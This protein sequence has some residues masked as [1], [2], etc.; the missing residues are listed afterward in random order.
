MTY[1]PLLD[2]E[3]RRRRTIS[4]LL[5]GTAHHQV[6]VR[7]AETGTDDG[8]EWERSE[9]WPAGTTEAARVMQLKILSEITRRRT[10]A[11]PRE[12]RERAAPRIVFDLHDDGTATIGYP[13]EGDEYVGP[14]G[15]TIE[16]QGDMGVEVSEADRVAADARVEQELRDYRWRGPGDPEDGPATRQYSETQIRDMLREAPPTGGRI[17]THIRVDE[18]EDELSSSQRGGANQFHYR[19][20]DR[21]RVE[22]RL[23]DARQ[24]YREAVEG[25]EPSA[26]ERAMQ[27]SIDRAPDHGVDEFFGEEFD[28]EGERLAQ[29]Y[30]VHAVSLAE[31]L[32]RHRGDIPVGNRVELV[33]R[34]SV[35]QADE[36]LQD[37][38]GDFGSIG[39][40]MDYEDLTTGP[41]RPGLGDRES[42]RTS[43]PER[44][45]QAARDLRHHQSMLDSNRSMLSMAED[46]VGDDPDEDRIAELRDAVAEHEAGV[47]TAT[48][49]IANET[50]AASARDLAGRLSQADPDSVTFIDWSAELERIVDENIAQDYEITRG[51]DPSIQ[52]DG[53]SGNPLPNPAHHRA[54]LVRELA[55]GFW[56]VGDPEALARFERRL[57]ALRNSIE[58]ARRSRDPE[59]G[60]ADDVRHRF[61]ARIDNRLAQ[62]HNSRGGADLPADPR[63]GSVPV[64]EPLLGDWPGGGPVLVGDMD[65]AD[66]RTHLDRLSDDDLEALSLEMTFAGAGGVQQLADGTF[67]PLP[68]SPLEATLREQ[69]RRRI[70]G[71]AVVDQMTDDDTMRLIQLV[72][73]AR[74]ERQAVSRPDDRPTR[75]ERDAARDAERR[76]SMVR[77]IDAGRYLE[78]AEAAGDEEQIRHAREIL[79]ALEAADELRSR[80]DSI[81][82]ELTPEEERDSRAVRESLDTHAIEQVTGPDG[83]LI[84]RDGTPG[85]MFPSTARS[86]EGMFETMSVGSLDHRAG[87]VER[88]EV[89]ADLGGPNY[90]VQRLPS[91]SLHRTGVHVAVFTT[92]TVREGAPEAFGTADRGHSPSYHFPAYSRV[93]TLEEVLDML[94]TTGGARRL[95][96]QISEQAWAAILGEGEDR[97]TVGFRLREGVSRD[98]D[99]QHPALR[100]RIAGQSFVGAGLDVEAVR[101]EADRPAGRS[102][103]A[104]ARRV[105]DRGGLAARALAELRLAE[106]EYDAMRLGDRPFLGELPIPDRGPDP[107]LSDRHYLDRLEGREPAEPLDPEVNR[108]ILNTPHPGLYDDRNTYADSN[109][110]YPPVARTD[111]ELIDRAMEDREFRETPQDDASIAL[112]AEVD[113]AIEAAEAD[114]RAEEERVAERRERQR[115][116]LE[117]RPSAEEEGYQPRGGPSGPPAGGDPRRGDRRPSGGRRGDGYS[118]ER[119]NPDDPETGIPAKSSFFRIIYDPLGEEVRKADDPATR[120]ALQKLKASFEKDSKR[121]FRYGPRHPRQVDAGVLKIDDDD[122][123]DII[124]AL[125]EVLGKWARGADGDEITRKQ[126]LLDY[127]Q[128]IENSGGAR[129]PGDTSTETMLPIRIAAVT[130][131]IDMLSQRA[132]DIL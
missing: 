12:R 123:F 76:E 56:P 78:S 86:G 128:A 68:A 98:P 27:A 67:Q 38:D 108:E 109:F 96:E 116:E 7:I 62:I 117:P 77:L 49:A 14:R 18:D 82:G 122:L 16:P 92:G 97:D 41:D 124:D 31:D 120:N 94:T 125:A 3:E 91:G 99:R 46:P 19:P 72:L 9:P 95:R 45:S 131:L 101:T 55:Q 13:A 29:L 26:N 36:T 102:G 110:E 100:A 113:A 79:R 114:Q 80:A 57:Q 4:D 106:Q 87:E 28:P 30:N 83:R 60:I 8:R 21:E 115:R 84:S 71:S 34:F 47:A 2:P 65:D 15:A 118:S 10:L 85:I 130:K 1:S 112:D 105:R 90:L 63:G 5:G 54:V 111:E 59:Q 20:V 44:E 127:L 25:R 129:Q 42:G 58:S 53:T 43:A 33:S 50:R 103:V 132:M 17:Q 37:W 66:L 121:S 88:Y 22:Q 93:G 104:A 39:H 64:P 73:H 40:F 35:A 52:S 24:A 51:R 69:E 6:L 119:V 126:A 48:L 75:A 89:L 61:L 70:L 107:N 74:A 81:F 32:R 23:I 11:T